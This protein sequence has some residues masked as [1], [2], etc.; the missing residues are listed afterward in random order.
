MFDVTISDIPPEFIFQIGQ[1]LAPSDLNAL[2]QANRCFYQDLDS[3]LWRQNA[4]LAL[5][6][7]AE[8]GDLKSA[9][10]ALKFGAN[11]N[12]EHPPPEEEWYQPWGILHN[13]HDKSGATPSSW[14]LRQ[15]MWKWLSFLWAS[16]RLIS[17]DVVALVAGNH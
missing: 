7:A 3:S 8:N 6:W 14:P 10:K 16:T 12:T 1:L 13:E 4:D 17:T 11:I 5:L 15:D 9:R 2:V